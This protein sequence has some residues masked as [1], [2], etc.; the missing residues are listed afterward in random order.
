MPLKGIDVSSHQGVFNWSAVKPHID[1]A[2]LRSSHG[3]NEKDVQFERNYAECKRLGIPVGVYHYFYYSDLGKHNF[4]LQNFLSVII[5]KTFDFP[6][7]IDYEEGNFLTPSKLGYLSKDKLTWL[8]GQDIAK[9]KAHGFK[10]GIYANTNWLVNKVDATKIGADMVWL[11]QY[12]DKPTYNGEYNIW[13]FTSSGTIKGYPGKLDMNYYYPAV[14]QGV[15]EPVKIGEKSSRVTKM[16]TLLK[17]KAY[18]V[19]VDGVFGKQTFDVLKAFQ[20][21]ND[22]KADGVCGVMT[23]GKLDSVKRFSLKQDGEK[24]VSKNFK[25]KE[26]ACKDGSGEILICSVNVD[27]LQA[28]RD[29][30]GKPI[31]INSGYRTPS[32]NSSKDVRGAYESLHT[33]GYATDFYVDG[34]SPASVYSSLQASHKGGLGKYKTFTHMD[35]GR[36]RR[37]IG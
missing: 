35:S 3:M 10:A 27:R 20:I 23:W 22:L 1:F 19:S 14:D 2:I 30:I 34:M 4:E 13:Q 25:V 17:Q 37:W 32:Y 16:Q 6:A 15:T 9:I 29:K 5:G 24:H 11:A 18:K 21:D 28:F 31:H 33:Y 26:F 7:F 36:R 12:A 8:A